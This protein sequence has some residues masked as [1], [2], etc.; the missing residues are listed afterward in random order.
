MKTCKHIDEIMRGGLKNLFPV[1]RPNPDPEVVMRAVNATQAH[2]RSALEAR[3]CPVCEDSACETK[4][5]EC[6]K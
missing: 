3:V 1:L 4:S 6:G 2:Y 5:M